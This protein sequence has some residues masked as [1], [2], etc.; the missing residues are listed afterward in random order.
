MGKGVGNGLRTLAL[1][2]VAVLVI[3]IVV[4]CTG[5]GGN[6]D[7]AY[8]EA[9]LVMIRDASATVA[10]K[11]IQFSPKG[12]GISPGTTVTWVNNDSV[13]HNVRQVESKFL[14][15]DVM[16]PGEKF[17]FTFTEPGTYRYVCTYHHPNMNGVV[18]VRA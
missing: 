18:V 8:G 1:L 13:A 9:R 14:S 3:S 16:Q 7:D 6:S 17:S 12:I 2:A 4:G 5:S 11:D 10:M 15:P